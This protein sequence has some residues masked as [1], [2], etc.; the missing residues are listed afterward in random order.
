MQ[1]QSG[2]R[3]AID[4]L[5]KGQKLLGAMALGNPSD[6]LAGHDVECRVQ[7]RCSMAL[8]V[9]RAAFY[10]TWTQRQHRLRAIQSLDLSFLVNRQHQRVI[11][12]VQIEPNHVDH[13]VGEMGIIADLEGLQ[14]MGFE[15]RSRPELSNLPRGDPS[16]FGHQAN[17]P[18]SGLFG[19]TLDRQRENFVDFFRP[20]LEW[21]TSAR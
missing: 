13:L 15:V 5:Q 11:R 12:R 8:I 6:D 1:I 7:A 21:L 10:L 14:A 19:N 18:V 16:I 17:A 9:V 4:L 20:K 3:V 2:W